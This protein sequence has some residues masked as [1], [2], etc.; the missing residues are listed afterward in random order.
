MMHCFLEA[1]SQTTDCGSVC[2]GRDYNGIT[3]MPASDRVIYVIDGFRCA[4]NNPIAG[5]T[6]N[7]NP[8]QQVAQAADMQKYFTA[9]SVWALAVPEGNT[10]DIATSFGG[11]LDNAEAIAVYE[12]YG[13]DS[14]V[15]TSAANDP[16]TKNPKTMLSVKKGGFVLS[17]AWA[18]S[19][20]S[21]PDWFG[22]DLDYSLVSD[23][24]S[25]AQI[26]SGGSRINSGSNDVMLQSCL[27][28]ET[29]GYEPLMLSVAFR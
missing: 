3:S 27:Y 13:L 12:A 21:M 2:S 4:P 15:P 20:P 1:R 8:A 14:I 10:I 29:S 9:L 23:P 22:V 17:A 28:K 6:I 5:L 18:L 25:S 24:T 26:F 11:S 16:A 7:G 19:Q